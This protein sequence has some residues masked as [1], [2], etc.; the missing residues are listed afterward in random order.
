MQTEERK[1]YLNGQKNPKA[2]KVYIAKTSS[3]LGSIFTP[4]SIRLIAIDDNHPM[5]SFAE[6]FKQGFYLA[7]GKHRITSSFEK[8]DLVFL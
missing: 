7:P 4:S 5:T 3:L 1:N 8:Q 2:A 6:G